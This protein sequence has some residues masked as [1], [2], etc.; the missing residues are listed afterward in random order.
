M[1]V[2]STIAF[3]MEEAGTYLKVQPQVAFELIKR[4]F[5]APVG[6][7]L[8]DSVEVKI[9]DNPAER[10]LMLTPERLTVSLFNDGTGTVTSLQTL[11]DYL[12]E[13]AKSVMDMTPYTDPL[14]Q[15]GEEPPP[16]PEEPA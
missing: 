5:N 9:V 15:P 10:V 11:F 12:R 1:S 16:I 6:G 7:N 14:D 13:A 3:T 2:T 8:P 4:I